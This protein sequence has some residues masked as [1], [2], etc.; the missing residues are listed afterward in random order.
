MM[1]NL[2]DA[3]WFP[4]ASQGNIYSMTKLCSPSNSNKLLVAS[5]K[6][7]IYSCEYHQMTEF[8][9]PM[10]KEL[11]FTYIPSGA[12]I[13]SID[14]YNKSDT[15]DSFV[16]GITIMKT[17]TDTIER[18]L[19]IYTEGAID[20]EGDEGSSI[21][22]IAQNCLMVELSYTPYHL[23]HTVLSQQNFAHE[24]VWLI[25]GSDY[26]IH[27]I[28]EDKLSHVYSESSIEKYFPELHDLQAI[29]L[30]INIY[31]YDN[32]KR[33]VTA[34]GCECGL[35]KVAVINVIDLQVSQSWLLR[36]D[37]PVPSVIIFPH[38]NFVGKP[39]FININAEAEKCIPEDDI[40]K[41]NIVISSTS[42]AVV[43]ENILEYGMKQDVILSGSESSDCILCCCIADINMDGQNEI[44][45]G[46]YGQEVLIF[47]L[48]DNAW[49]LTARK[50]FDAPVH[51]ISYMDITNDGIKEL[52]V[53]TQRGVHILQ[54]N[55]DDV[56]TKWR[57]RYEKLFNIITGEK[58]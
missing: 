40:P 47:V 2:I 55:I 19:N 53:L 36:Y 39:A 46:T 1:S 48:T 44:L 43:F 30:W 13:I 37:K 7:K 35:V 18:Y 22:A 16:I 24:V 51:S 26:R 14:A 56:R 12:E 34:V 9:R 42:N 21:E 11:L 3:H 54:H 4:L 28:R 17:S 31:Y 8:L 15:G 50:L 49:E 10:V 5:L 6:R 29:A 58:L 52:I 20:G 27:M 57:E 25:S 23:Y 38:R 41:L 33:R 45:L 32:Y